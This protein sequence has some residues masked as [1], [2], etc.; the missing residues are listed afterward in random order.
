MAAKCDHTLTQFRRPLKASPCTGIC[1]GGT[2]RAIRW[3]FERS[4]SAF[5]MPLPIRQI[6][7]EQCGALTLCGCEIRV[8]HFQRRQC[9]TPVQCTQFPEDDTHRPAIAHNVVHCEDEL[10]LPGAIR[11]QCRAQQG[12]VRQIERLSG[13]GVG[14]FRR[15]RRDGDGDLRNDSLDG[16]PFYILE[17]RPQGVMTC[18]QLVQRMSQSGNIQMTLQADRCRN[19]IKRALFTVEFMKKPEPLLREGKRRIYPDE[20]RWRCEGSCQ[21]GA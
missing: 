5:K 11:N 10:P 9:Y 3:K 13:L 16:R 15:Q 8:L 18:D 14:F 17:L 1:D 20:A 6:A 2:A 7:I 4:S 12:S 21:R 19:V